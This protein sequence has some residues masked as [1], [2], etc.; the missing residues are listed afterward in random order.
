MLR[1]RDS[2]SLRKL[3]SLRT[4]M[5]SFLHIN[6]VTL[7]SLHGQILLLYNLLVDCVCA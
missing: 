7:N 5:R 2:L 1:R 4:L 3:T 6:F